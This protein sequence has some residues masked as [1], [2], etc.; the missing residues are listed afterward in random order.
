MHNYVDVIKRSAAR[1]PRAAALLITAVAISAC[2]P[3]PRAVYDF[4]DG[5]T[6]G[7]DITAVSDDSGQFYIPIFPLQHNEA[8]QCPNKFPQGDPLQD[9]NGALLINGGQMGPWA[10]QSGF[11]A[12]SQYW[13]VTAYYRGLDSQ[14]STTWQGIKGI[15]A[16]I[17]DMF[18]ATPGH[19]SANLGVRVKIGTADQEI[20]EVDASG[21]PLFHAVNHASVGQ[22]SQIQ[23]NLNIPSN[24]TVYQVNV[25]IRGDWKSYNLY[26]GGVAIDRVEPVK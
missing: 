21:K 8:T 26:E 22:F 14:S 7:W 24:A 17:G 19:V 15:K 3:A 4:D 18:G 11:P 16:C 20:R 5:T 6:Q 13:E 25:T 23:A 9:K 10:T 2:L 12:N 1:L